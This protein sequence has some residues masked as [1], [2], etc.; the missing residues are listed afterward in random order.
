[1]TILKSSVYSPQSTYLFCFSFDRNAIA[2]DLTIDLTSEPAL[3]FKA[4]NASPSIEYD[5][6]PCVFRLR[7]ASLYPVR[8]PICFL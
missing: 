8:V 5:G 3:L 7:C 4:K 6:K 1:M 2:A